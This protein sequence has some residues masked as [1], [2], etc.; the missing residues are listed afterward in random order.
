MRD[1]TDATFEAE[2]LAAEL[3]VLVEFT[4][5]WCRPC[6]AIEPFLVELGR[7]HEGRLRLARLDID[8]N[9]GH[10]VP[11]RGALA[12]DGDPLRLRRAGGDDPRG[13]AAPPVR[14]GGRAPP[15]GLTVAYAWPVDDVAA[16]EELLVAIRA[17]DRA[18]IAGCFAPGAEL[19]ALTPHELRTETGPDA[20][21]ERYGYWLDPLEGF[22]VLSSDVEQ[23]ADR[24]RLRYRFAGHDPVHGPQE[25][26]HTAY[27]AVVDG[28]VAGL[29]L[30]CTGFRPSEP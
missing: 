13:A 5:P 1:V 11:L 27:V 20:I 25:N 9:L 3:P 30:S 21:A 8:E 6:E 17:R 12:A 18:R 26:E 2:V 19:R 28:R 14:R 24:V 29:N 10:P 22:A 23:V 15:P 7:E 4:A 16:V